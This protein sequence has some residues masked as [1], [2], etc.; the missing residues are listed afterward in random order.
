MNEIRVMHL[1]SGGDTG[2]AKTHVI[3]LLNGLNGKIFTVL[4]T[5]MESDFTEEA[6]KL[7]LPLEILN[8]KSRFDLG[9][10]KNIDELILEKK[11]NVIHVHGARANF[12]S[13]F[14]KKRHSSIPIVTTIHSD[15]LLDDYRGGKLISFVFR[16]INAYSLKKMDNYICVSNRFK[17]MMISRGFGS[18]KSVFSVYNGLDFE[19]GIIIQRNKNE[20]LNDYGIEINEDLT[21]VGIMGRL[22]AVKNHAFFIDVAN[23]I[24]QKNKNFRFLIA[25]V[26]IL[27]KDLQKQVKNYGIE[28]YIFFLDF[29]PRPYE[30]Y[31]A[32]DINTLT[33]YSESFPYAMLEGAR[34]KKP[35]VTSNVGGVEL[36]VKNSETG[37][38]VDDFNLEEFSNRII[39]LSLDKDMLQKSGEEIYKIVKNNFSMEKFI[40]K[41]IEIYNEILE[42]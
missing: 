3:N 5:L 17:E 37:F 20:F 33:S 34:M 35:I 12:I 6:K 4:V 7:K 2:G 13:T 18:D 28:E 14:I 27:K 36:V 24:I 19:K 16:K 41:H 25:G 42:D 9:I 32:I 40:Q 39:E 26:G 8:Q 31:N 23:E 22:D 11:I 29:I 21:Y 10:L 15:Y 1:I 30:F 38:I